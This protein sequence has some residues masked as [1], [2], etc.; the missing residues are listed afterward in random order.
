MYLCTCGYAAEA[1]CDLMSHFIEQHALSYGLAL[2]CPLSDA[3]PAKGPPATALS[4][5]VIEVGV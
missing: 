1:E 3:C 4:P 5:P 2:Y